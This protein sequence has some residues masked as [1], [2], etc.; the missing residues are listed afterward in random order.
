MCQI[1]VCITVEVKVS[2]AC[3]TAC[4]WG[5]TNCEGLQWS[6][7]TATLQS[8][9]QR[10]YGNQAYS[11]TTTQ[12][13]RVSTSKWTQSLVFSCASCTLRG[14][15]QVVTF[16]SARDKK[17]VGGPI[18][19]PPHPQ[20]RDHIPLGILV[21]NPNQYCGLPTQWKQ[22]KINIRQINWKYKVNEAET[23]FK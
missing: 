5:S 21:Q 15:T 12:F 13:L 4:N 17:N 18:D 10:S 23:W 14:A 8:L 9:R 20:R 7:W 2:S 16:L 1:S 11:H 22:C 6:N 3:R 19:P